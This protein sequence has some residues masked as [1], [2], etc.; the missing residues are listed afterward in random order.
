MINSKLTLFFHARNI[1]IPA[2]AQF[3]ILC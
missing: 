3:L 2:V 1:I